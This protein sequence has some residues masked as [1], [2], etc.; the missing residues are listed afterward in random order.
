[1]MSETLDLDRIAPTRRPASRVIGYQSWR[2]LPSVHWTVPVDLMRE[3]VPSSLELDLWEG[4]A[5]VGLVPFRMLGVRPS[6]LPQRLGFEFLE[7]NVRTYVHRHGEPGVYFFSLE[8]ANWLAVR[9]AR[10]RWGLPYYLARM[11]QQVDGSQIAFESRRAGQA[12]ARL[13]VRYQLGER[14]PASEP[15]TLEH[16]LL[17][18]YLMFIPGRDGRV[19]RGHVY[20]TPYPAQQAEILEL[21]DHLVAAAGFPT[22]GEMP[23]CVHY[24]AGVDVE[25]FPMTF[26]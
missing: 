2:E 21:D 15:G 22:A 23:W 20:H 13:S 24:A 14:L 4:Q 9:T 1:M 10:A 11:N 3:V 16:F 25:I 5:L 6:W 12:E 26:V 7:A 17:E 18:R 8:A 19:R